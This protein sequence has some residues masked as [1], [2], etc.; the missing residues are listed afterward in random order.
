MDAQHIKEEQPMSY[1]NTIN[2]LSFFHNLGAE[3]PILDTYEVVVEEAYDE[4][5]VVDADYV[6][7]WVDVITKRTYKG[8]MV[9][10]LATLMAMGAAVLALYWGEVNDLIILTLRSLGLR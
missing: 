5:Y 8:V 6:P 7:T 10:V 2:G 4:V 3:E 1:T 9:I